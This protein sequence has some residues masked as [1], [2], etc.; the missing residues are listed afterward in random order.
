MKRESYHLIR[1][2]CPQPTPVKMLT[3]LH[4]H[5]EMVYDVYGGMCRFSPPNDLQEAMRHGNRS[6]KDQN[7]VYNGPEPV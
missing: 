2:R 1:N 4:K 7:C 5:G 6:E 3:I